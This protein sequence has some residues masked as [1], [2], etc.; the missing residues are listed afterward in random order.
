MNLS[1]FLILFVHSGAWLLRF[2][3]ISFGG[4]QFGFYPNG[5]KSNG[6][7]KGMVFL[8]PAAAFLISFFSM[9]IGSLMASSYSAPLLSSL[10]HVYPFFWKYFAT[11]GRS[12]DERFGQTI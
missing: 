4:W 2:T 12:S 10:T 9:F 5:H 3:T 6:Q 8:L 7:L 1:S 11:D